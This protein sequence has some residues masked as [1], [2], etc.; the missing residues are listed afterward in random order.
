[1]AAE[2]IVQKKSEKNRNPARSV[3]F[4]LMKWVVPHKNVQKSR[5]YSKL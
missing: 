4:E 1:M 2:F 5:V 3:Y